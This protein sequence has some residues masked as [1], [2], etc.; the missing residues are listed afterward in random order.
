[1]DYDKTTIAR[2]Y[3]TGTFWLNAS[4]LEKLQPDL[5]QWAQAIREDLHGVQLGASVVVGFDRF[6]T[7]AM[8]RQASYGRSTA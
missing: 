3:D 6:G 8:A 5:R 7:F 1:M 2:S 4:G